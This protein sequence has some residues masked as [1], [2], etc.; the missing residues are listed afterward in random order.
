MTPAPVKTLLRPLLFGLGWTCVGLG[1]L[2]L[3]LPLLPTTPFLLLAAWCFDRSS[4]RL[5]GWLLRQPVLGPL[6]A[7]WRAHGVIRPRAKWLSTVLLLGFAS[8]PVVRGSAPEWALLAM[9]LVV[10]SVLAFL[11]SRPSRPRTEAKDAAELEREIPRAAPHEPATAR[12]APT[13]RPEPR[14]TGRGVAL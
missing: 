10:V 13:T 9:G 6:L 5:H 3:F 12:T 7:D 2:G 1:A 8:V 11:W 14:A 4:P